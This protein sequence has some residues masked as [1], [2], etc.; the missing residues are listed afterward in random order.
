MTS[1]RPLACAMVALAAICFACSGDR[2]KSDA[3]DPNIYRHLGSDFTLTDHEGQRFVLSEHSGVSLLFFGFTSC[4]D[5]CPLTMSR[6]AS[7]MRELQREDVTVLFISVDPRRDTPER[8]AQ[9]VHE[10]DFPMVGLTSQ[11]AGQITTLARSFAAGLGRTSAGAIDHSSRIYLLD[12]ADKVC[13]V[14]GSDD[15]IDHMVDAIDHVEN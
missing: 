8:L 15:D 2:S 7:V 14:F 1:P 9:Y 4:P 3:Q 12:A 10:Y 11:D 5:V 13:D 6:L